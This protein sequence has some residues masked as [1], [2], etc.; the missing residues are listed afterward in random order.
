MRTI[1]ALGLAA[2][3]VVASVAA[4]AQDPALCKPLA[5]AKAM[6]AADNAKWIDL[7]SEQWQ[8]LRGVYAMSPLTPPGLPYGDKAALAQVEGD[9]AGVIFFIDKERACTPMPAPEVLIK[10]LRDV[11]TGEIPKEGNPL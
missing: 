9:P 6:A 2:A 4:R 5:E 11:A 1:S 7:T 8:F 3:V 10:M